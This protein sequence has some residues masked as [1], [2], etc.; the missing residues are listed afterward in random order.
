M[1]DNNLFDIKKRVVAANQTRKITRTM[2]M[3][4]SSRMQRGKIQLAHHYVWL[5]HM[6]KAAGCLSGRYFEPLTQAGGS[7]P[8]AYIVFG[9]SK[10]LSGT[11]SPSVFQYAVPIVAGHMVLS[12]GNAAEAFFTDAHIYMGNETPSADCSKSIAEAALALYEGKLATS[13]HMIYTKGSRLQ[14][15]QLLPLVRPDEKWPAAIIAEPSAQVLYPSLYLEYICALVHEAHLQAFLAEQ[16]ARVSAMDS[17]T[18]NA[19][20]IIESLQATYN[21]IRQSSITH[22]IITVSNAARGDR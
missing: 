8:K 21:R 14:T 18:Q 19:D 5:Q 16:V 4:A 3:I 7:T 17:A 22:E 2:E 15:Q 20:E 1:P 9:G 6:Q 12:V 11:Y 10:G 13:I